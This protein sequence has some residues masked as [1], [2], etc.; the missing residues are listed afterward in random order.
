MGM[1]MGQHKVDVPLVERL[2]REQF[3]EWSQLPVK[4]VAGPG[5]VNAIFRV[6]P[7]LAAR[8]PLAGSDPIETRAA[9]EAETAAS[10]ELAAAS[11]YPTPTPL[12]I[13]A[14][15]C[16]YPLPWSV[17]TWLPG[18]IA[19]PYVP[20]ND[21]AFARDLVIL[22]KGFRS[23]DTQGRLF[24]GSGRG[25]LLTNHDDWMKKCFHE[26]ESLFDVGPL[27]GLWRGLR[28]LP[29][30]GPDVMSHMD[31]IPANLLVRDGRLVGLLDGGG[32]GPADPA[33]DLVACW[34]L[35]DEG[36]RNTFRESLGCDDLEW[37]RGMAWAF[38]QAMGLVWYYRQTNLTM[39]ELGISTLNRIIAASKDPR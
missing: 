8:F 17:Q 26:S 13:G 37:D 38:V 12:A 1:H 3:P 29:S 18:E 9:I 14:A 28:E 32:F 6:G 25:G 16:G 22:I 19:S 2:L 20:G 4:P 31:L 15:G 33:L 35:L 23:A 5:T 24:S 34:H 27:R 10:V 39:C 36:P 21:P 11:V 30:S 7:A